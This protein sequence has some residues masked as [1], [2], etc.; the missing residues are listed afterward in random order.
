[1]DLKTE[2]IVEW[3]VTEGESAGS[4]HENTRGKIIDPDIKNSF[5]FCVPFL[6]T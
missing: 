5:Q 6:S 3:S 2:V 4:W 1:M